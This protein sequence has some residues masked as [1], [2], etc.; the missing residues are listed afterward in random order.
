VSALVVGPADN[1]E[2]GALD[3]IR[4]FHAAA[5]SSLTMDC[6]SD[7]GAVSRAV[8]NAIATADIVASAVVP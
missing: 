6:S 2:R 8:F 5:I 1:Y 4:M 3:I 7:I